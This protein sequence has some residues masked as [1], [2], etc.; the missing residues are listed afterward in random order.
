VETT[1]GRAPLIVIASFESFP[2]RKVDLKKPCF[3]SGLSSLDRGIFV[4]VFVFVRAA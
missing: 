2:A 3:F 1:A 4:Y